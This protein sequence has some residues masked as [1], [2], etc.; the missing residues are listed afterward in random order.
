MS[1]LIS[2][3]IAAMTHL[4]RLSQRSGL[5]NIQMCGQ[6]GIVSLLIKLCAEVDQIF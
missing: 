1:G 4:R 5:G 3:A 2:V 6:D